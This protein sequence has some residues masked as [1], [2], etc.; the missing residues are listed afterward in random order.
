M[1]IKGWKKVKDKKHEIIWI[2]IFNPNKS[3]RL[4]SQIV[5]EEYYLHPYGRPKWD[6][7]YGKHIKTFNTKRQAFNFAISWMKKHPKG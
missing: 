4:V 3:V 1:R 6:V 2:N 7:W 5:T